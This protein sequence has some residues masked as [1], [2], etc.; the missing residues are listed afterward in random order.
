[1]FD[2]NIIELLNWSSQLYGIKHVWVCN[3]EFKII[4]H[5]PLYGMF[6]QLP[7]IEFIKS[8]GCNSI[9]LINLLRLKNNKNIPGHKCTKIIGYKGVGTLGV[10]IHKLHLINSLEKYNKN[11]S[12]EI[13]TLLIKTSNLNCFGHMAIVIGHNKILHSYTY[14]VS[15]NNLFTDPGVCITD[16]T[17]FDFDFTCSPYIW[18]YH[19]F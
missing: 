16:S 7:T 17:Y 5:V 18:L 15:P 1:M 12:Y 11:K 6:S 13:G 8:N 3:T 14:S 4:N 2:S 9:G 10:W 19:D